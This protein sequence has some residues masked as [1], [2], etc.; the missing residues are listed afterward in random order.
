MSVIISSFGT[1]PDGREVQRV[2]LENRNGTQLSV[3][4]YGATIQSFL[5]GGVDVVLGF[6]TIDGYLSQGPAYLGATVGRYANRIADGRFKLDGRTVDVG[7]NEAGR[8]HLHGGINGFDKKMWEYDIVS[9]TDEPC[10]T[11]RL[12]SPDGDEGYPG[13]LKFRLSFLLTERDV[14]RLSYE[15]ETDRDTVLNV[16]QH[17]YFNLNGP[18][19]G[20]VLQTR[21]TIPARA[22][23]LVD[24]R[25]IPTGELLPVRDTPFDFTEEKPIGRD[26]GADHPQLRIAGGYDHTFVLGQPGVRKHAATAI[27][28]VSGLRLDCF[29]DQPGVQLY[30][31]NFLD[32]PAGKGGRPLRPYGAFC[33]E[34]QHF[35]DSPNQP[36][37]PSAV[38]RA[39]ESFRSVTEYRISR[40]DE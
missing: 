35:P 26:I 19:G 25:L 32:L 29:T 7:C 36:L 8:G 13:T 4:T 31:A 27:S 16:T 20:D 38:L 6:D 18:D 23:V 24:E 33:L 15:A 40:E 30:T 9:Q 2:C 3:L 10:V 14:L 11:F 12:V 28:P 37:F 21:L 34:T 5:F 17:S 1:L 22:I 39:G